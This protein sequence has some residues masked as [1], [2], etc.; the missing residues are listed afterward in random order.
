MKID[1]RHEYIIG[2]IDSRGVVMSVK[3]NID[4]QLTHSALYP[5]TIFKRWTWWGHQGIDV[6]AISSDFDVEDFDRVEKHLKRKYGII[7]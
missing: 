5:T 6:S 3:S 4:E 1:D 2:V 7:T